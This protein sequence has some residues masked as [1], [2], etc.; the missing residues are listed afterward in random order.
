VVPLALAVHEV[1]ESIGLPNYVKTS[2]QTGLH[3]LIP[4]GGQC[5]YDQARTLAYLIGMVV[6]HRH[7]TMATTNRNPRAR[8]GK[9]YLDWGQN[10]HGQL[11]VSPFSVRP[12]AGATVSMP[13]EWHEVVPGLQSSQFTIKNALDRM[14]KLGYD[15]VRPVLEVK[16]DLVAA[17]EKL[18]ALAP[19]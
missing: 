10:A 11:L 12:V 16:P 13:L 5:T 14:E 7:R 2:G 3:I 18:Q 4:L 6:E 1:C 17:L 15:P 8:G 19:K 9:V